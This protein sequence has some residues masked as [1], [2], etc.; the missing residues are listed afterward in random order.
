MG[1]FITAVA[2]GL[3]VL[4]IL[5]LRDVIKKLQDNICKLQYENMLLRKSIKDEY[6]KIYRLKRKYGLISRINNPDIDAEETLISCVDDPQ[7]NSPDD[8]N[9]E[10]KVHFEYLKGFC[11]YEESQSKKGN[12]PTG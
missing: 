12:N 3:F 6:R 2:A 1:C 7:I 5:T 8:I 9:F 11:A 4:L 10:N